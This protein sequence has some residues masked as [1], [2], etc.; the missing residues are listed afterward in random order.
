[1]IDVLSAL[2]VT[3]P[4][5]GADAGVGL[6][7]LLRLAAF[8]TMS[9]AEAVAA[10]RAAGEKVGRSLG[11]ATLDELV[12][13]CHALKLGV[14]EVEAADES[15]VRVV[16]RECVACAGAHDS[17]QA[18]CHFEGGL[19]AG[20]ISSIFGRPVRVRET[21]CHGGRGDDACRFEITFV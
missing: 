7:R 12:A 8:D 14:V 11:L 1:M 4:S 10:A 20:A 9:G 18:T 15:S 16:V 17:G 13:L 6:Y 2:R 5:L 19:V 3:R 21:A